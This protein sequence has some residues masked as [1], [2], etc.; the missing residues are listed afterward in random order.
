MFE[1]LT[2]IYGAGY[3]GSADFRQHDVVTHAPAAK[4]RTESSAKPF[5]WIGA[6]A[7]RLSRFLV[8]AVRE[9]SVAREL[10]RLDDRTLRDIGLSRSEIP[11]VAQTFAWNDYDNDNDRR[12]VA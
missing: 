5:R 8:S 10:G 11:Y 1:I 2:S 6:A 7:A 4:T 9:Q 3:G 12:L